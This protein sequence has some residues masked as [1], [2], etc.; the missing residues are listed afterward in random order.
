M[1]MRSY[2]AQDFEGCVGLFI[3]VFN[4]APWNNEWTNS[5]ATTFISDLT[6]T[7][8]FRAFVAL[9]EEGTING[10]MLGRVKHWWRGQE[11][12]IDEFYVKS[13]VQGQ[14]IGTRLLDFASENLKTDGIHNIVLLTDERTPAYSYYLKRGYQ[15]FSSI[16]FLHK[17]L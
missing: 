14:G 1:N 10:V 17:G 9:D 2:Q 6:Q 11:Y 15:E 13:S 3:D 12:Y 8:G 7:P 16:K 4:A 5:V